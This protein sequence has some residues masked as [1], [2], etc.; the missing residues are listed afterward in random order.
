MIVGIGTDIVEVKRIAKSAEKYG[1]KFLNKIFTENEL[2]S[3]T[4]KK[5]KF[6]HLAGKFA[7]K[8]A[9]VKS[10]AEC[11]ARGFNWHDME[12]LNNE[13]GAPYVV[14]HGKFSEYVSDG[15]SLKISISHTDT[16]AVAFAV[17]EK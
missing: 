4:G 6:Q 2:R 8:E 10:L 14:L 3:A 9:V 16:H 15:K 17:L 7:A 5:N 11:C 1:D 13:N 12:I